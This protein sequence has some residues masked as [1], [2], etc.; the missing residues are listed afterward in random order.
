MKHSVISGDPDQTAGVSDLDLHYLP[1]PY[2]KDTRL[3]WVNPYH[4]L[5]FFVIIE[6]LFFYSL[7]QKD[8][9]TLEI[10]LTMKQTL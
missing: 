4:A 9:N 10:I 1:M 2:K 5:L 3:I 8:S 7:C 6:M